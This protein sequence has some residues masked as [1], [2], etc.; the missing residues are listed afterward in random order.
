MNGA[1]DEELLASLVDL[2]VYC[3]EGLE[4][5]VLFVLCGSKMSNF[6]G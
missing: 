2:L 4:L 3:F 6:M 1:S 5:E